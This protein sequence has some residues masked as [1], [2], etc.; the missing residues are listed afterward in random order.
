M[1]HPLQGATAV[2]GLG[3]TEM[4]RVYRSA[5]EFAVE[6]V[7]RALEDAGL[8]KSQLDGLLVNAGVTQ[9]IDVSLQRA[10][11]L[12]ELDLL[13][14]MQGYGSS[15]G[16]MVQYAAMAVHA[17][18]ANVVCCVFADDPLKE[19]QRAGAAYAGGRHV[20]ALD[21]LRQMYGWGGPIAAYA[22]GARRHM[23]LYGTTQ[24]QLGQVAIAQRKW[25]AFNE[26]ATKRE[27]LDL[28]G[29]HASPW[30][31]EPFHVLD[32]CLVSNGGVAVIVTSAERARDGA[33]PPVYI[34]GFAQAHHHDVGWAGFDPLTESP[35]RRSGPKALAM[36]GA[37]LADVSQCQ[38][39]DCYTYTV[40]T[41]L[42]DYGFCAK[43]E[44]GPFAASGAIGR[45]GALPTNTGGGQLS[46]YYMWGMTPISEAIIQGR[47]QGGRR[48]AANQ[49]ILVS[50]NGGTLQHH[51]TLLLSPEAKA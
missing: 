41:T 44:G 46:S 1:S 33:Q 3:M 21:R 31:V 43:G 19:G 22:S 45:G 14:F 5:E 48:Q 9:G 49:L 23:D 29:Y 27:P 24:D 13:T 15:A 30:V 35:A 34:R 16:Q 37:Q 47:G 40:I 10:L 2:C 50:G 51:S 11:G 38:L 42:E 7:Y 20:S 17:G 28:D 26:H 6:A 8:D 36:A 12:R 4:G 18:L 32:C 25:A 39:Y